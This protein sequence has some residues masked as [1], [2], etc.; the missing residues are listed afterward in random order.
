M[1]QDISSRALI[2]LADDERM[3]RTIVSRLLEAEDREVVAFSDGE[4]LLAACAGRPPDA[5]V[6]DVMMPGM[7]GVELCARIRADASL[8]QVPL[9]VVSSRGGMDD[10]VEA[11]NA[12]ANDYLVK[13]VKEVELKAK[14]QVY[15][16]IAARARKRKPPPAPVPTPAPPKAADGEADAVEEYGKFTV[17]RRLAAGGMGVVYLA[18]QRDLDRQVALKVLKEEANADGLAVKR[19]FR[20][21]RVLAVIDHPNVVKVLDVG[22]VAGR[23]FLSMEYIDGKPLSEVLHRKLPAQHRL[24]E[25]FARLADALGALHARDVVHRDLKPSNLL[26]SGGQP[27]IIDFGLAC[28]LVD[29]ALTRDGEAWGTPLYMAPEQV[30]QGSL[31]DHRCDYYSLGLTIYTVLAGAHPF[32]NARDNLEQLFHRHFNETPPP[33]SGARPGLDRGWDNVVAKLMEKKP[34]RRYADAGQ[35]VDD[36]RRLGRTLR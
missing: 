30:S 27:H 11:F 16:E 10:I 15:L 17:L 34:A 31:A 18:H 13:P 29:P 4:E 35:I 20:E 33:V 32:E 25:F 5:I 3:Q 22:Q 23:Y 14:I 21:M 28:K 36:L 6:T 12:G 8:T 19:F 2:Y 24:C 7:S 9:L 26:V 1:D